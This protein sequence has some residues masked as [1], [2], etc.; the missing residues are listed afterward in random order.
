MAR[1]IAS[2]GVLLMTLVFGLAYFYEIKDLAQK[3][4]MVVEFLLLILAVM[5]VIR[6][7]ATIKNFSKYLAERRENGEKIESFSLAA[8]RVLRRKEVTFL[9]AT[10]LYVALFPIVGFFVT[11]FS[12]VLVANI[13]LGTRGKVKLI[14]IPAGLTLFTYLLFGSVFNIK[15]PSGILF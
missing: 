13:L 7:I 1:Y 2:F 14:A 15:L 6:T 4:K 8:R 10:A 9:A 12:Y 11:S 5:L 3:D